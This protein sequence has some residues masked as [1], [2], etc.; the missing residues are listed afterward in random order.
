ME[1]QDFTTVNIG[2]PKISLPKIIMPRKYNLDLHK[3]KIENENESFKISKIPTKLCHEI[4]SARNSKKLTQKNIANQLNIQL[5]IY[6]EIENGK[7]IYDHK[8]KEIIQKIQ[9]LFSV[10]FENK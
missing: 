5:N 10:K 9:R 4:I 1:H 6:N 7:A 2:K 8:T 3:I